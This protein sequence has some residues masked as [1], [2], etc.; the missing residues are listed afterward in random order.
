M[1]GNNGKVIIFLISVIFAAGSA[2][3]LV[4]HVATKVDVLG[5]ITERHEVQI[6][7]LSTKLDQISKQLDRIESKLN[8]KTR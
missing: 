1:K 3:A 4:R 2:Y 6:A 5:T 8:S 7:V